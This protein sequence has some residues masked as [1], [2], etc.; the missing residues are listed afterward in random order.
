MQRVE[1]LIFV[2]NRRNGGSQ[3][4]FRWNSGGGLGVEAIGLADVSMGR[5]G[6]GP[7]RSGDPGVI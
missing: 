7:F 2:R 1:H 4:S 3:N 6:P 5:R